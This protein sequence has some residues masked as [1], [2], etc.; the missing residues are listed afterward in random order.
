[1]R[2]PKPDPA[3]E[4]DHLGP[5]A[6]LLL[7]LHAQGQGDVLVGG[8][9]VEEAEILEHHAHAA[10]DAREVILGDARHVLAEKRDQAAGRLHRE[11]DEAKQRRLAGAGGAGEELEGI[12]LDRE[13]QVAQDL[14]THAVAHAHILEM[15]GRGRALVVVLVVKRPH[16]CSSHPWG[17]PVLWREKSAIRFLIAPSWLA[18][19]K[20]GR[21]P[22]EANLSR[23]IAAGRL[24]LSRVGEGRGE[25][26]PVPDKMPRL[27]SP[28]HRS[29]SH[30]LR[31]HALTPAPLP[32]GRGDER[33]SSSK[34][35]KSV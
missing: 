21:R 23:D 13:G 29:R 24:S 20:L 4:L 27:T 31:P 30:S 33:S 10:A 9:V 22:R 32:P 18:S 35:R 14:G 26:R 3:Q 11:Q 17:L 15:H 8:Q 34:V 28:R 1:M 6:R 12:G 7:A 5:I 16:A 2:S 25:G 19:H